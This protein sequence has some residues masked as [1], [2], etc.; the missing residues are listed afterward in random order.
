MPTEYLSIAVCFR[1]SSNSGCEIGRRFPSLRRRSKRSCS[2]TRIWTTRATCR[3]WCATGSGGRSFAPKRLEDLCAILLPDSG[4]LQEK[5]AEAANRHGYT[6]HKPALPLYTKRDAEDCLKYFRPVAFDR[7]QPVGKEAAVRFLVAGHILGAAIA[8]IECAGVTIVF[9]GDLGRPGDPT[10]LDPASV[11]KADYLVVESTYGNRRH[12]PRDPED[13]LAEVV[14]RTVHRGGTILVPAFAVGR[15][16]AVLYHLQRLKAARRIPDVPIYLDSP[17]AVNASRV[18]CD[19]LGEHRLTEAECM[20][21]CNVATYVQGV[22]ESKALDQNAA[23][24]KIIVSASGMATGGR[25][26]HHL[27][28]YATDPRNIVLFTGFQAGGTRGAAMTAGA[29]QVKI[30]GAYIPILA[31]VENLH[32]LSAHADA[33]EIVAWLRHFE[34]PPR[35]TFVTHGEPEASD[36]LRKRIDDELGW[37]SRVPEHGERDELS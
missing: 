37:P 13:A 3:S 26:L 27:K 12:D 21:T 9:S 20:A 11:G 6:K 7:P 5:D 25:I 30:H 34:S 8:A 36:A 10:M 17:M 14:N 4:Y 18:F 23:M 31:E 28:C 24:P 35:M 19:H 16:Q 1:A 32:M 29:N 33:D 2:P 15:V 22:E